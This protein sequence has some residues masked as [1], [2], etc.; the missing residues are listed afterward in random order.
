MESLV[1][2]Q[3]PD[4]RVA[5]TLRPVSRSMKMAAIINTLQR[6]AALQME[7]LA[8]YLALPESQLFHESRAKYCLAEGSNRSSKTLT[9]CVEL[10]RALT[11][12][13]P[14][15]KYV[16]TSGV[17]MVVGLKEDN[18]A[19][20]WRKMR[21]PGAFKIIRDEHTNLWRAVRPDPNDP[22]HLDPYDLA[23]VE[24]WKDSPPLLPERLIPKSAIAWDAASKGIPRRVNVPGTG[25]RMEMRPSGSRPDQGDHYNVV[26]N[27]E[28]MDSGAWYSEQVRGLVGLHEP[29]QHTPRMIWS[30]TSQVANPAFAEL[31]EKAIAG[32]NGYGRFVFL[33]DNNPY[34]S[35]EEKRAMYEAIP[36]HERATRYYGIPATSQRVIY[37]TYE[38]MGIHGCDPF[39]LPPD[40]TRYAIV[41]PGTGTCA[42]LLGAIDPEERHVWIYGGFTL[43]RAEHGE[44]A[45][46]LKRREDGVRF[47]AIIMDSRA[48]EQRSFNA[49][50]STAQQFAKAM[51]EVDLFPRVTGPM[52]GFIP[53]NPD[54]K[55]RT[56]ALR[57]CLALR[58]LGSPF[59]GTPKLQVMKGRVPRLDKEIK[60]ALSDLKDPEKRAKMDNQSCDS[61][62]DLEYFV[63]Y[64]PHY[65]EPESSVHDH[66]DEIVQR[67]EEKQRQRRERN[68]VSGVLIG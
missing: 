31:R 56:M 20:L 13:D 17:A 65:H 57:N 37:G 63:S 2:I 5:R 36:E 18:I 15:D 60:G 24:K 42:T 62:D 4:A 61:L 51:R 12:T 26:L 41:D 49:A 1:D 10:C 67:F 43:H 50:A 14:Y 22:L 68:H 19:M 40:W 27:D 23:Y 25:W 3:F 21:Q 9:A 33:V 44:W 28:E 54:V 11:G 38:P 16:R 59:A 30:A 8:L 32:V 46:E 64:D 45:R 53:G 39:E 55:A 58:P 34:V 7:G 52:G 47:E 48:G 6:L 35:D 66:E 29:P